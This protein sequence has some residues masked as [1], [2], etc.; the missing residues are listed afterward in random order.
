[1]RNDST[2]D[3][4]GRCQI[5]TN[6]LFNL[7]RTGNLL[8]KKTC[9][10]SCPFPEMS[11]FNTDTPVTIEWLNLAQSLRTWSLVPR[12][13]VLIE[14]FVI[15]CH[16]VTNFSRS[17]LLVTGA[18]SARSPRHFGPFANFAFSVSTEVLCFPDTTFGGGFG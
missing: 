12:F 7:F 3:F 4:H 17:R 6:C 13:T 1:M 2:E 8:E 16:Q 18:F 11:L 10:D 15:H 5:P 14:N 9:E